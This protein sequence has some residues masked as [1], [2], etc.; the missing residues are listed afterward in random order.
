M[1][2]N[3]L[4]THSV[5]LGGTYFQKDVKLQSKIIPEKNDKSVIPDKNVT[6]KVWDTGGEER[7]RSMVNLYYRDAVGAIIVYDMGNEKSFTETNY[8]INEMM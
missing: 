5:T 1:H 3:F 4:T 6:L 7:F 8:W 2:G